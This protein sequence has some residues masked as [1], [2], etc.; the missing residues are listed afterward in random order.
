MVIVAGMSLSGCGSVKLTT[1]GQAGEAKPPSCDFSLYTTK[2]DGDWVEIAV[3][4]VNPGAYGHK[5]YTDIERFKKAI[6]PKVCAAGGDAAIALPNGA[7]VYIKATVLRMLEPLSVRRDT[8]PGTATQ[9]SRSTIADPTTSGCQFD[10][11]CK[12]DRICVE[13][14]CV[15]PA[16]TPSD[17][18]TSD[19]E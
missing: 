5:R 8:P 6:Q 16:A 14:E 1:T 10:T 2:P 13:G 17:A 11:Q 15:V 4:D 18:G 9:P 19:S 7:G 12:G 3:I